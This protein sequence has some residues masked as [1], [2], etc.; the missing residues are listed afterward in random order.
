MLDK[1]SA[2]FIDSAIVQTETGRIIVIADMFPSQGGYLQAKKGTGYADIDG[3][4]R[5]LLTDGKNTDKLSSFGYFVGDMQDGRATVF[6]R[7]DKTPTAYSI[8]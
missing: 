3:K 5:L 1:D 8:D 2:S 6:N 7:K 4:K